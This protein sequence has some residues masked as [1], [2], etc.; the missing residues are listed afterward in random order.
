MSAKKPRRTQADRRAATVRRLLAAATDALVEVGYAAAST[1][2]ICR[3]AGV[4]QG[5]LFRHFPTREALMVAV[6]ADVGEQVL[7]AYRA[8]FSRR[9]ATGDPLALAL[10]LLRAACRS[11]PNQ[12]WYELAIAA[13]TDAKL[14]AAIACHADAYYRSIRAL[15]RTLLPDHAR[16]LGARFEL[17]VDTVI[18]LFDGEQFQRFLDVRPARDQARLELVRGLL[19][20]LVRASG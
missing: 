8:A 5:G 3:R 7:A 16:A 11:R 17:L 4:S 1:P 10:A 15:A 14:R 9:R 13:R 6:A 18:A 20:G 19:D 2:A 12:A